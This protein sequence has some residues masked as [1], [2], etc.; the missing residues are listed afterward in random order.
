[1]NPYTSP[2]DFYKMSILSQTIDKKLENPKKTKKEIAT[3]MNISS[4]T[5]S[6]IGNDLDY[7]FNK[8]Y[9]KEPKKAINHN[10]PCPYCERT[11]VNNAGLSA[12][13]MKKHSTQPRINFAGLRAV[14]RSSQ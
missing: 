5:L 7:H 4:R 8:P 12:H 13:M 10:V 9:D 6:R 3:E 2:K 14:Q 11:C 1:M